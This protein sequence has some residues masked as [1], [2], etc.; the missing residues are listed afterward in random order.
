MPTLTQQLAEARGHL[1]RGVRDRLSLYS[2][3]TDHS[4]GTPIH[5]NLPTRS[6]KTRETRGGA[7]ELG[8]L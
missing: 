5:H 2:T 3:N 8:R 1:R 6:A 7:P 4:S